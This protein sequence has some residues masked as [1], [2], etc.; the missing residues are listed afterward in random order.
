MTQL[1]RGRMKH[2]ERPLFPCL[3]SFFRSGIVIPV[4]PNGL[5]NVLIH[6]RTDAYGF[7]GIKL[8]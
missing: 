6:S 7:L 4:C 3:F 5:K 1:E 8:I 2:Q